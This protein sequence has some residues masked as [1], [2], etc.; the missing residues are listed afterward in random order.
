VEFNA[1]SEPPK[2]PKL[3][4]DILEPII[5]LPNS[6]VAPAKRNL[7]RIEEPLPHL[8]IDLRL[9]DEPRV[10]KSLMD[11][12]EPSLTNERAD[13]LEPNSLWPTSDNF[14]TEPTATKPRTDRP[15]PILAKH[16]KERAEPMWQKPVAEIADPIRVKERTDVE[17]PKHPAPLAEKSEAKRTKLR[18]DMLLPICMN[19]VT[20]A[21]EPARTKERQ[22]Q[23]DPKIKK[24]I[25]ETEPVTLF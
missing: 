6:E 15:E 21:A 10:M 16:L 19:E 1:D 8:A 4:T 20:E 18:I 2:R 11:K 3:R 23:L 17:L 24:F 7:P 5:T 22:L 13:M 12:A 9:R 14:K 25:R